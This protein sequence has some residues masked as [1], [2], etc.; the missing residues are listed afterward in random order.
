[1]RD[2]IQASKTEEKDK[3]HI[4][5]RTYPAYVDLVPFPPSFIQPTFRMLD[6][7]QFPIQNLY[8]FKSRCGMIAKK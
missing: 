8:N 3:L 1:M 5:T 2:Q 7:T 4:L 6:G